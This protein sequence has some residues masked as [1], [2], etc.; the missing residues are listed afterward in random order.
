[1]STSKEIS[2]VQIAYPRDCMNKVEFAFCSA[3]QKDIS[4][5]QSAMFLSGYLCIECG[6]ELFEAINTN[7]NKTIKKFF[8]T[9]RR[10]KYDRDTK[11]TI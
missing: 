2:Y 5:K 9:K 6:D 8:A 3:C 10:E 1:M 11:E 4:D 7:Q